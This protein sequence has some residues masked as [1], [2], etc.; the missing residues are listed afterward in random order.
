MSGQVSVPLR[1]KEMLICYCYHCNAV[2]PA[3][4]D[5]EPASNLAPTPA[6]S[7]F[8]Q[9]LKSHFMLLAMKSNKL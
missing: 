3:A 8:L 6:W 4:M 2:Q 5:D 9:D 7:G 1:V